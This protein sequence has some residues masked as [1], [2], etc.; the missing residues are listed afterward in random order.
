MGRARTVRGNLQAVFSQIHQYLAARVGGRIADDLAAEAFTIAFAQRQ[1]YD[2]ARGCARPWLYGIATNVAGTYRRQEQR[3]Y[4][5]FYRLVLDRSGHPGR[6]T[7]LPIPPETAVISGLALSPDGSKLA[8]SLWPARGQTGSKIQVFSLATGAGQEWAWPG[9]GAI[10]QLSLGVSS[11][12]LSWEA[13]NRTLLFQVTT[14]YRNGNTPG[15]L[16]LLDTT[17]PAGS[18]LAS[19]TGIPVPGNE[20]GWQHGNAS[21]RSIGV[22]LITGDGTKLVAPFFHASAQPKVFGFTITEFS[23]HPPP[24]QVTEPDRSSA[25]R[26]TRSSSSRSWP[27]TTRTPVRQESTAA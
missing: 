26:S 20:V 10:G 2:P 27:T 15:Q 9:Q 19:S 21:H 11:G 5:T 12:S 1:R 16:R 14:R 8:V 6:L 24:Y 7:A 4:L 13:N 18:L 23:V 17:A 22:P 25:M 3:R